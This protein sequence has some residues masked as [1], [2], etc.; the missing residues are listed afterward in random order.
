MESSRHKTA[1]RFIIFSFV[2]VFVCLSLCVVL[3]F[4]D[5]ANVRRVV[6]EIEEIIS[7]GFLF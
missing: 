4:A 2:G 7:S 1:L 6:G 5:V 3:C